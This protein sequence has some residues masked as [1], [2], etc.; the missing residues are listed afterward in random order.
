MVLHY[1]GAFKHVCRIPL[2]HQP[3][4]APRPC[5]CP[6]ACLLLLKLLLLGEA[7]GKRRGRGG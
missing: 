6:C 3:A 5:P 2:S 4:P 7:H 1:Y